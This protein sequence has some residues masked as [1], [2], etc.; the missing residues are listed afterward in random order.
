M[1]YM[2][3]MNNTHM[4]FVKRQ[5]IQNQFYSDLI[6]PLEDDIF[7][8]D[9]TA[10]VFYAVKMG[11]KYLDRYNKHFKA[12]DIRRHNMQHEEL[13]ICYP[14]QWTEEVK[15]CCKISEENI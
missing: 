8:H 5:S 1:L 14:E 4:A 11:D 6:T 12:P 10:R 2:F 7:V 15:K 13:L 3:G 9:T